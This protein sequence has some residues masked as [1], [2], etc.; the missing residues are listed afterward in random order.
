MHLPLRALLR[1]LVLTGLPWL[2][3]P[4]AA[5]ATDTTTDTAADVA[6]I[7]AAAADWIRIYK[8][9]D[10]D[11][12]L[13]LYTADPTVALHGK[14]VLRGREAVRNFFAPGI[15]KAEVSFS[16]DVETIEV[17]GDV[18]HLIS[19]YWMSA[20]PPEGGDSF[21]DAGRSLLIY[22]RG[23]DGRWRIHVDIDQATPDVSWPP[24]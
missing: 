1:A 24:P 22:K 15:G 8:S 5:L 2:A 12:L 14:P 17:H 18:A 13:T 20:T 16:I 7:R 4:G 19:K 9:G 21:T 23:A 10:L 6:A 11:A 3:L